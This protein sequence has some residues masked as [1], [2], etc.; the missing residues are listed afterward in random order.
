M[1]LHPTSFSQGNIADRLGNRLIGFD[2]DVALLPMQDVHAY[3]QQI[4][5]WFFEIELDNENS[6]LSVGEYGCWDATHHLCKGLIQVCCQD[7][8]SPPRPED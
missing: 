6:W 3:D 4:I 1:F 7:V 8:S 2:K 5:G